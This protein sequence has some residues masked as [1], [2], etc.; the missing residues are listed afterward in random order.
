[1]LRRFDQGSVMVT[2]S[3]VSNLVQ[4]RPTSPEKVG[5][6]KPARIGRFRRSVQPPNLD[7]PRA[8]M[9]AQVRPRLR[10]RV[11]IRLHR[12]DEVWRLDAASNGAGFGRPTFRPTSAG[13]AEVGR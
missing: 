11:C 9:C 10:P 13:I 6:R 12:L 4:P 2:R 3:E 7:R 5:R 8:R 1:M